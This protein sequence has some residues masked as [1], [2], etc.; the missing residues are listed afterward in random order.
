[1]PPRR[2]QTGFILVLLAGF[3]S[4]PE[5]AFAL[6]PEEPGGRFYEPVEVPAGLL[7]PLL[8]WDLG[9]LA[10]FSWKNLEWRQILFQIDECTP[11]GDFIL[12]RGR[13]SNPDSAN[14]RLDPQDL[15][16]FMARDAGEKAPEGELPGGAD[17][18]I[19]VEIMDPI[20]RERTWVYVAPYPSD[21]APRPELKP[22]SILDDTG[23]E[24][25]L[26]FFTYDYH[27]LTNRTKNESIPTIFINRLSVL[28]EGGGNGENIIDRQKIRGKI[29][30]LGGLIKVP[31]NES[32][33]SGGIVA[34]RSGP[35][36]I[37]THSRM[38]PVFPLGIKG[39]HFYLDSILVDT[40]TL[41]TT[42]MKVPFDPGILIHDIS[43]S[44]GTDLTPA[45]KGMR[46][47]SSHNREGFL[48]DGRM[49]GKEKKYNDAKDE[50]RLITG[51]QGTQIQKTKFDPKF[52]TRGK[53]YSTYHDNEDDAHPPEN[54]PGDIGFSSD[55]VV[56][57]SLPAGTYKIETFGCIPADFYRPQGL[58]Q[59]L[60]EEI[61]N[62]LQSP[63]IIKVG[64][65]Q[66]ENQGGRPR[67]LI[68][69]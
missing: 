59:K 12:T 19:P 67:T 2:Y 37:L 57:R 62:V 46:F 36:R 68:N 56:A 58:N 34:Y 23:S 50:W 52:L 25:Y 44:F 9:S 45:A 16:V 8:G 1:M 61:L 24:F 32:I 27:A 5:P 69:P 55:R 3:L 22:V 38:Y 42:T 66:V 33:V 43:L 10:V 39:P 51:P 65:E 20:T 30:F 49:D 11:A 53:S 14:H 18:T 4:F 15:L 21:A 48:I 17:R 63:L 54:F 60:L 28:P 6:S 26:R 7:D 64:E 35:V 41:T 31:F 29:S 13:E 47:F 40:L